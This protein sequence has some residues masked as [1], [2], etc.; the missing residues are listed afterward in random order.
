[1]TRAEKGGFMRKRWMK[2]GAAGLAAVMC[3]GLLAGCGGNSD[4]SDG[5]KKKL[6]IWFR[7]MRAQ[8]RKYQIRSFGKNS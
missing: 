3:V 2:L 1:M 5:G 4:S 6:S 8:M 7:R